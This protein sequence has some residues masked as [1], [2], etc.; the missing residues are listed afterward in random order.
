MFISTRRV[1][2]RLLGEIQ[3]EGPGLSPGLFTEPAAS[4]HAISGL[5]AETRPGDDFIILGFRAT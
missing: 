3:S 2:R 5:W 4:I 1:G